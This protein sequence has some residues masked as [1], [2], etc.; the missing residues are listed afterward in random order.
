VCWWRPGGRGD[1]RTSVEALRATGIFLARHEGGSDL[2]TVARGRED[3]VQISSQFLGGEPDPFGQRL[4]LEPDDVGVHLDSAGEGA[5]TAIDPGQHVFSP[6]HVRVS[7][8]ALSHQFRVLDEV[9]R[10]VD[11]ARDN[12]LAL[13][14]LDILPDLP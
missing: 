10:G 1:F 8:N 11:H 3:V 7:G 13:R 9:G 4:E 5:K 12:N 14:E 2:C 6:D